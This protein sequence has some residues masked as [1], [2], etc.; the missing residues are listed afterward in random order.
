MRFITGKLVFLQSFSITIILLFGM[1]ATSVVGTSPHTPGRDTLNLFSSQKEL[2]CIV[3]K[4]TT[5]FRLFAPRATHVVLVLYEHHDANEGKEYE[6]HHDRDGVWEYS[7][8]G[9]LYGTFYGYRI[10]GPSGK[11]EMFNPRIIIGD[12]YAKAVVT[13]NNYRHPAKTLIIDTRYDWEGDTWIVPKNHNRLI[14]YEAHVRDLTA[15]PSSGIDARGTYNGLT[16]KGRRGGLSYL[17]DLGINAIELYPVQKFGAIELPYRDDTARSDLG[18]V[19]TWNPYARN[20][21]GYMTSYFFAPETYYAT[22]GTMEPERYNGVDGRAVRE[23]KDMVK[24][25]H[26][27]GIAVILDVVYNHVSQYDYNPYKYIDKR[28]YFRL[29][30]EGNFIKTSGCGNDFRTE[31]PMARRM[32]LESVAYWMKEYHVDG[33]RFDLAT[34]IDRETCIEIARTA[35]AIN[36]N[37]ILI[38]E[39]WGG[40]TYDPAGFSDLGWAAW[41]DHIRNGIKGQNPRDG[42]GFIF[43]RFQGENSKRSIM[44]YVTGTLRRDGGLFRRK[45][46]SIN[47]LESHDDHTLGDFIRIG[48]GEVSDNTVVTD[49]EHHVRLTPRQEALNKLAALALFTTQGPVMIHEGQEYARSKVIAR[50]PVADPRVGMIDHNSYEKDNETNYLDYRHQAV[51]IHLYNYYRGLIA[52]RRLHPVLADAPR[53]LLEFLKTDDEFAVAF[54]YKKT[55]ASTRSMKNSVV[56]ILNGNP[57]HETKVTLPPGIWEIHADADR[58]DP[59]APIRTARGII[60]V[61]PA[62]GMILTGN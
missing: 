18:E 9:A 60:G 39:P 40:G 20:H 3:R 57:N 19:N 61:P 22:D 36:P 53:N 58:V 43:G 33:F 32:I 50:T 15:H 11:G 52:F 6:M 49:L 17:K 42:L 38:A 21:W 29:D 5:T 31:R 44:R 51:N 8:P 2:G 14:V 54:L 55:P 10:D 62:S 35:R 12:P 1:T 34:L 28:Y 25:F 26:R 30:D 59:A 16:E 7:L 45:E 27:E 56:V 24:T 41:N 37:V 4:N 47:Y 48:T 23:F 13:K 46:H